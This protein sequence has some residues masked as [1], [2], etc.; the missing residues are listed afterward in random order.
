MSKKRQIFFIHNYLFI[1]CLQCGEI[2]FLQ[3]CKNY[4]FNKIFIYL[5][6]FYEEQKHLGARQ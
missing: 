5:S 3:W 6:I 4:L 2:Q 1:Y